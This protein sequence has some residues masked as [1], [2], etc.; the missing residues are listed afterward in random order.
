MNRVLKTLEEI[1]EL[2]DRGATFPIK[3]CGFH[4]ESS[5]M[6]D[7]FVL[8]LQEAYD[9]CMSTVPP[10]PVYQDSHGEYRMTGCGILAVEID[11]AWAAGLTD[12]QILA[13][14]PALLHE[15]LDQLWLWFRRT[16]NRL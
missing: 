16:R 13:R 7:G 9:V 12:G 5:D 15:D 11:E 2:R 3:V 14:Y 10:R 6:L 8:G 1:E 4:F